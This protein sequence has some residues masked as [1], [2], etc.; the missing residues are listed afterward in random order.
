MREAIGWM[1]EQLCGLADARV[2]ALANLTDDP[3][4]DQAG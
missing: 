4:P 2:C 3:E 1:I